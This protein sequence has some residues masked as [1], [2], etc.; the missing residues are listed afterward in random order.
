MSL[1]T[2]LAARAFG[3]EHNHIL[4]SPKDATELEGLKSVIRLSDHIMGE[5]GYPDGRTDI[6]DDADPE[7]LANSIRDAAKTKIKGKTGTTEPFEPLG[8]KRSLM[9]L[10]LMSLHAG[11][12]AP[13]DEISLPEGSPFGTVDVDLEACTLCLS[14]VGA[15]PANAL[16]DTPEYPRLSFVESACVQCGIC[17]RTCPEDAISLRTRL[18]FTGEARNER[19]IKED[20][21]YNCV[22]CGQP[23]GTRSTIEAVVTK[24]TGHSMFDGEEALNRLRMCA[25]CRVVRL[26]ESADDPFGGAPRPLPK[27]A[28]DLD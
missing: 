18:S 13:K 20:E 11:A 6:L 16:R 27:T 10:A 21:P 22:S 28:D 5:L 25:D 26:A 19:T 1:E 7:A 9:D 17:E 2:L 15:C 14:C 4:A 23:F 3:A 24:M 8:K 12:P